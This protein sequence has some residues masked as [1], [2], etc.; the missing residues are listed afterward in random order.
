[1]IMTIVMMMMMMAMIEMGDSGNF[2]NND[3]FREENS[4]EDDK[5]ML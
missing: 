4:Y 2:K 3:D 5:Y 1:M